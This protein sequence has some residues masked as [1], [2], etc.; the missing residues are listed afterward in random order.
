MQDVVEIG[1]KTKI[2]QRVS[3]T[4]LLSARWVMKIT[5]VP[6]FRKSEKH[7]KVSFWDF[8]RL[9]NS[10]TGLGAVELH[11]VQLN[12]GHVTRESLEFTP[13]RSLRDFRKPKLVNFCIFFPGS[14]LLDISKVI[15]HDKS[16][17]SVSRGA[18][19]TE[20]A[21]RRIA[22]DFLRKIKE[23]LLLIIYFAFC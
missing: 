6:L 14:H 9:T 20:N 4:D 21:S 15:T 3:R 22:R 10:V 18:T 11:R 13:L 12:A 19:P 8:Y 2:W 23:K 16:R 7:L 1:C 5:S 17:E